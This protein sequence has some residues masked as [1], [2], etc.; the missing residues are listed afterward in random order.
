L[1]PCPCERRCTHNHSVVGDHSYALHAV[2]CTVRGA[3][4]PDCVSEPLNP[5]WVRLLGQ[6]WPLRVHGHVA[7]ACAVEHIITFATP[8]EFQ[9]IGVIL[10]AI[11]RHK[12]VH[13]H[14]ARVGSRRSPSLCSKLT[15]T[16]RAAVKKRRHRICSYAAGALGNTHGTNWEAQGRVLTIH[17]C[18]S[19]HLVDSPRAAFPGAAGARGITFSAECIMTDQHVLEYILF[20]W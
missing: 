12:R 14:K 15:S 9:A 19:H 8:T 1:R 5:V 7:F 18:V 4:T 10:L 16:Q 2:S 6:P 13:D 11:V 20:V 17:F 3:I